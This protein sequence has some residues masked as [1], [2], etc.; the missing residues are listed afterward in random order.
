[1][2][3]P[4]A[5]LQHRKRFTSS[6]QSIKLTTV[7]NAK[8]QRLF[9]NN[10]SHPHQQEPIP[11]EHISKVHILLI[12]QILKRVNIPLIIRLSH[13]RRSSG[14]ALLVQA[15]KVEAQEDYD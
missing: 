6:A 7:Y 15:D 2:E 1:L 14:I 4:W 13:A 10:K 9:S 5:P 12:R 8:D 3:T 11:L